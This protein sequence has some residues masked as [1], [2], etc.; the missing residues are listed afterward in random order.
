MV[1]LERAIAAARDAEPER[2][3]LR[4]RTCEGIRWLARSNY[5]LQLSEGCRR[6]GSRDLPL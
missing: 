1:E 2:L 3:P 6:L 5:E 4:G